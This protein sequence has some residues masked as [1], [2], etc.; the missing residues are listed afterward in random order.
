MKTYQVALRNSEHLAEFEAVGPPKYEPSPEGIPGNSGCLVFRDEAGAEVASFR[1]DNS[2]TSSRE[3]V[4][5]WERLPS[6]RGLGGVEVELITESTMSGQNHEDRRGTGGY[7]AVAAHELGKRLGGS[8][9]GHG[10]CLR[11]GG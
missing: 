10:P 1:Y 8:H 4:G 2:H 3:V 9:R 6:H 7:C 11:C 5:W